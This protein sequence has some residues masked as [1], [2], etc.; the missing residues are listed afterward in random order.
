MLA[1]PLKKPEDVNPNK[2][3]FATNNTKTNTT[4]AIPSLFSLNVPSQQQYCSQVSS[5]KDCNKLL[6]ETSNQKT[7]CY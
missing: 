4:S 6:I 1:S 2:T 3:N 7:L 5:Q